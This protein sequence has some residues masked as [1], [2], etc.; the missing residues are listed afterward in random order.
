[1]PKMIY[2]RKLK[3][4]KSIAGF[5]PAIASLIVFMIGGLIFG[6]AGSLKLLAVIMFFYS[7][8]TLGFY[9]FKTRSTTYLIS[10]I[11]LTVFGCT[12]WTIQFQ[13]AGNPSQV[14]Q[15]ITRFFGIWMVVFWIWLLYLMATRKIK[16]KGME[17]LELAA[18]GVDPSEDTYTERPLPV[19]KIDASKDEI[20]SFAAFLSKNQICMSYHDDDKIYLVPITMKASMYLVIHPEF[21]VI[22]K[23]WVS[24]TYSGEV[25]VHISKQTYLA[26]RENL[27]FDH[28]CNSMGNL[29]IEFFELYRKGEGVRVIDKLDELKL[30]IFT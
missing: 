16:W 26:Y 10:G 20:L 2:N 27:T 1:V 28:L 25:S 22:E 5:V 19:R 24:F 21:N 9:Y 11:Y 15:P 3:P 23:T 12:L 30:N 17:V 7:A 6:P 13:Y 14:F 8:V 29:F 4:E 18:Q